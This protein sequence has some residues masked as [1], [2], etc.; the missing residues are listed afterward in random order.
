MDAMTELKARFDKQLSQPED[1][2]TYEG[3]EWW[4]LHPAETSLDQAND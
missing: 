4:Q 3:G 2:Q 1:V